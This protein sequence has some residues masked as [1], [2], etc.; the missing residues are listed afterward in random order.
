MILDTNALSGF[1]A[2]DMA[3]RALVES[4]HVVALPVIVLG[5]YYFGLT[6]SN[7][8]ARLE[9]DLAELLRDVQVLDISAI[10]AAHYAEIRVELKARARPIPENDLWIAALA[11][12]HNLP[13]LTRDRHFE[14]VPGIGRISW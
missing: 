7:Q 4:A 9:S 11:R 6:T 12:Q 3:V 1:L 13:I 10:T 8:R 5:E 14:A 2:R